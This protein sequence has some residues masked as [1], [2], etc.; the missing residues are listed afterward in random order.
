MNSRSWQTVMEKG[1][2]AARRQTV[3]M[4]TRTFPGAEVQSHQ[5]A[6]VLTIATWD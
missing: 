2:N 3:A 6:H 1:T 5:G 4:P